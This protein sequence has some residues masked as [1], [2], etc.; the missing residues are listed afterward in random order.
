MFKTSLWIFSIGLWI[1][2]CSQKQADLKQE[3]QIDL[4]QE[5]QL[6]LVLKSICSDLQKKT[7]DKSICGDSE[8]LKGF[9]KIDLK[10]K[11]DEQ[12]SGVV[13]S[14]RFRA[15]QLITELDL[16]DNPHLTSLP[17]F[18]L[19]LPDLVHLDISNT[20]ISDFDKSICQLK[21]LERLIGRNNSYKDDEVPFHTFCLENLEVLDMSNS[22]IRY[23]DEYIGKLSH[24]EELH[25]AHNQ[26]WVIPLMLSTLSTL[27]LVDFKNNNLKNENFH[28][29]QNCKSVTE[30]D[31][32]DCQE[33]LLDDIECEFAH[34]LPFQRKEPL[35]KVYTDIVGN[36]KAVLKACESGDQ[37][38][39]PHFVDTCR[40][41]LDE[42]DRSKCQLDEF[43][44]A[45]L[46]NSNHFLHRDSC[47]IAWVG[48]M[49]DYDSSS[50][51]VENT[52]RGKTIRELRYAGEYQSSQSFFCWRNPL[53]HLALAFWNKPE[54][55]S[56]FPFEVFPEYFRE[57]GLISWILGGS[58][59]ECE[60]LP[61]LKDHRVE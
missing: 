19:D 10:G 39:C 28:V 9:T 44:S 41:I 59:S 21:K 43:E 37:K 29:A 51:F 24:L 55:L 33:N 2:G 16:S 40:D 15:S 13:A 61:T 14:S 46:Q 42:D 52:I 1:S 12:S 56:P 47:Y 4:K 20:G 58:T 22:D 38:V 5:E 7:N 36:N 11:L 6:K 57:K 49:V 3:E 26:M 17:E 32:E 54:K 53:E 8:L 27:K 30:D 18:V 34:E 48:W 35:R 45:R 31:R 23:I 50:Q 25:M 60:H